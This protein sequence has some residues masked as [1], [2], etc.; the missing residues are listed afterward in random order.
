MI[1]L[2]LLTLAVALAATTWTTAYALQGALADL[3]WL[4]RERQYD[5]WWDTIEAMHR[6]LAQ[7]CADAPGEVQ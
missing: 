4:H 3:L 7:L 6:S 1:I 5:A 2:A